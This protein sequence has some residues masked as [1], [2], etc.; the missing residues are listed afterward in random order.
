MRKLKIDNFLDP[1]R[2]IRSNEED[3]TFV[4]ENGKPMKPDVRKMTEAF[5]INILN[6]NNPVEIDK[7]IKYPQN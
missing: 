2:S 7:A 6:D 5:Q 4:D 1:Y 3:D